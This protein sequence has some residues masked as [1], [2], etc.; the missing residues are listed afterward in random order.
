[1]SKNDILDVTKDIKWIGV[2]DRKIKT[3]DIV[4]ET[5]YGSTYNSYYINADK[6]TLIE[7]VKE[8][9]WD[10]YYAKLKKVLNPEEIKYIVVNH[11]EPDHSG[12]LIKLLEIN[13]EAEVVGSSNAMRYLKD[14]LNTEFKSKIVK[15][16]DMLDL[17][18]KR[19]R[20]IGAPNL[21]WP[22]T[23][24]TYLEDESILF[25]CDCFGCHFCDERMFD[26]LT[27]NFDE[28]FKYYFD[29]ILKPYSKFMLRAIEKIE[30]LPSI[31]MIC[32]GHGPILRKN[33][34]K[35][36]EL[37]KQ[38]AKEAIS[39]P[40]ENFVFVAY[41]SA[42]NYTGMLAE[43][44]GKGIREA[45]NITV[46]VCDIENMSRD[47]MN[48]MLAQ[49]TGLMLGSPTINQNTLFQIY[50]LFSMINPLRDRS[51]MA[52]AFGSY[53]WSG[54]SGDIIEAT[55][56]SL[57][58]RIFKERFFI[59]LKPS[60]DDLLNAEKFGKEFAKALLKNII[61]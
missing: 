51:K 26:D 48:E 16:G 9:F 53:G 21:H 44:I 20:F 46:E 39:L 55:L 22:D 43:R 57:K 54:E 3:F 52:A 59:K 30:Q 41:V 10:E 58:F 31:R 8:K 12:S 13:P 60:E 19:L 34:K 11:T 24:F 4:M 5:K 49:C 15:D 35:Y 7:T 25:T 27:D 50:E 42:Y 6:I 56:K 23:M 17:G 33:W 40:K 38:Y 28:A 36:V 1:M 2:T 18:N 32:P 29:V 45:G 14:I 47:E 61:V 37:S